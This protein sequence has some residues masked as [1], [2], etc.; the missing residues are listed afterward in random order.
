MHDDSLV[1]WA[2]VSRKIPDSDQSDGPLALIRNS[3]ASDQDSFDL[4]DKKLEGL[5]ESLYY[6]F[7]QHTHTQS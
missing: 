2:E 4:V 1:N 6:S 5:I 3:L 7:Q